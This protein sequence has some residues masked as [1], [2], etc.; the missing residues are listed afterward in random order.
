MI[1]NSQ[2]WAASGRCS[3]QKRKR[4]MSLNVL[5]GPYVFSSTQTSLF[6]IILHLTLHIFMLLALRYQR[7]QHMV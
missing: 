5:R 4:K 6:P 2:V 7:L 3:V 1:A